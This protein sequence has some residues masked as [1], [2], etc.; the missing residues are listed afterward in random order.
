MKM[1]LNRPIIRA[2]EVEDVPY[3]E[4]GKFNIG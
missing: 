1:R 3:I 2:I 4:S